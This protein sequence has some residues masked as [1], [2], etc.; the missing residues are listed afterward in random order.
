M[1]PMIKVLLHGKGE[2]TESLWTLADISTKN[3]TGTGTHHTTGTCHIFTLSEV[4][5]H[6]QTSMQFKVCYN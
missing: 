6:L 4:L 1:T 3:H 2:N 5:S